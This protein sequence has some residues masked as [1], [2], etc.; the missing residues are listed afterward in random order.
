VFIHEKCRFEVWLTG[1]NKQVQRKFWKS[2]QDVNCSGYRIPPT[3]NG[4]NFIMQ[5]VLVENPNFNDLEGLT[6]QIEKGAMKFIM[7]V[8]DF[9]SRYSRD[10][11]E[12]C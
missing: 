1:Y 5:S 6:L 8:E 2:F 9:L 3:T 4:I 11:K 12:G 7:D 10:M